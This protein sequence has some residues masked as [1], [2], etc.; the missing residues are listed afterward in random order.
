MQRLK[1]FIVDYRNVSKRYNEHD[2][3][4][5]KALLP[6]EYFV[7]CKV[8]RLAGQIIIIGIFAAALVACVA[9]VATTMSTLIYVTGWIVII[10]VV[11][12][13]VMLVFAAMDTWADDG[14]NAVLDDD[15]DDEVE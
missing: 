11:V 15:I 8:P 12:L 13:V 10:A 7:F 5:E 3:A 2:K 4:F 1:K 14:P 6:R 9:T